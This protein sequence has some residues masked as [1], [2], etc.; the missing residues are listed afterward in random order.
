MCFRYRF[1]QRYW[2]HPESVQC[3]SADAVAGYRSLRDPLK[4]DLVPSRPWQMVDTSTLPL[5]YCQ[6]LPGLAKQLRVIY[7]HKIPPRCYRVWIHPWRPVDYLH[8]VH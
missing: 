6:Y 1:L 8:V 3:R 5:W 2:Y 4:H 7:C